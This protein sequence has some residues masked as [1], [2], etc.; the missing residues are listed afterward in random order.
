[1]DG[2]NNSEKTAADA[3]ATPAQ[4]P[5]PEDISAQIKHDYMAVHDAM[6]AKPALL[7]GILKESLR[8]SAL[9]TAHA[10]NKDLPIRPDIAERMARAEKK[11]QAILNEHSDQ[12][13]EQFK[14]LPIDRKVELLIQAEEIGEINDQARTET[15][16]KMQVARAEAVAA[17]LAETAHEQAASHPSPQTLAFPQPAAPA[18]FIPQPDRDAEIIRQALQPPGLIPEA[19]AAFHTNQSTTAADA[20]KKHGL[21]DQ[22]SIGNPAAVTVNLPFTA[23]PGLP[24]LNTVLQKID[25]VAH[26]DL[27]FTL[28]GVADRQANPDGGY[29][30][31]YRL[32][33]V[34]AGIMSS[35]FNVQFAPLTLKLEEKASQDHWGGSSSVFAKRRSDLIGEKVSINFGNDDLGVSFAPEAN[36][37][38]PSNR[39]ISN[40]TGGRYFGSDGPAVRIPA[41]YVPALNRVVD[42]LPTKDDLAIIGDRI[43]KVIPINQVVEMGIAVVEKMVEKVEEELPS[44][45]AAKFL[46]MQ[47]VGGSGLTPEQQ[48]KVMAMIHENTASSTERGVLP[49]VL[50]NTTTTHEV[51]DASKIEEQV[52]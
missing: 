36:Y 8:Q 49:A 32:S 17:H 40:F 24:A 28:K 46:L 18:S 21:I 3:L 19:L 43:N 41:E 16:E 27:G 50:M 42:A 39:I 44:V 52:R 30:Q 6:A 48:A 2:S 15:R 26:L 13:F 37:Q 31:L 34:G 11:Y 5:L 51:P 33:Y 47:K 4:P 22:I 1:V 9:D 10:L 45:T 14:H 20:P 23:I 7:E 29:D 35:K 25:R 38:T 12:L